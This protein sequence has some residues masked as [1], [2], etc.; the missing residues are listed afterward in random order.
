VKGFRNT[1]QT[2]LTVM[3]LPAVLAG[4]GVAPPFETAAVVTPPSVVTTL[5]PV[6]QS[7][8]A[9][10]ERTSEALDRLSLVEQT[11]TPVPDPGRINQAPPGL[12]KLANIDW[13]GPLAPLVA[14]IAAEGGYEFKAVGDEPAVPI[15]V[16][17]TRDNETLVEILRNVGYQATGRALVSVDVAQRR[18]EVRYGPN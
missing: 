16:D 13:N 14:R 1:V 10:A 9:A 2:A 8:L 3:A 11:R 7:L 17:I 18:I 5:D 4:C 12:D 6:S 15:V